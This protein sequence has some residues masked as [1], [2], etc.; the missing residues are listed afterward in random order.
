VYI[1]IFFNYFYFLI[2]KKTF[3]TTIPQPKSVPIKYLL[4]S[5]NA[6][7]FFKMSCPKYRNGEGI[8][9]YTIRAKDGGIPKTM[10]PREEGGEHLG[11]TFGST[12]VQRTYKIRH[13]KG[14]P[15]PRHGTFHHVKKPLTTDADPNSVI[16]EK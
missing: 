8:M 9:V 10:G 2:E 13:L 3:P 14:P 5:V 11:L 7:F 12:P 1:Y 15:P 16:L 4:F 6:D